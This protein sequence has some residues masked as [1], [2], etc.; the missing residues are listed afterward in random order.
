MTPQG[1]SWSSFKQLMQGLILS[2]YYDLYFEPTN[3]NTVFSM[4]NRNKGSRLGSR[5]QATLQIT[6][7]YTSVPKMIDHKGRF[8]V[9]NWPCVCWFPVMDKLTQ[10]WT[11]L[12]CHVKVEMQHLSLYFVTTKSTILSM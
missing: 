6:L 2:K 5:F 3:K 1:S 10:T 11:T 12:R 9:L 4:S 8:Y 7:I